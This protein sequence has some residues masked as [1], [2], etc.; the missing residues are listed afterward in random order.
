MNSPRISAMFRARRGVFAAR[1]PARA[2]IM[3]C[4]LILA[5]GAAW[6]D[7]PTADPAVQ[8]PAGQPGG[9]ITPPPATVPPT[10]LARWLNPATAPFLPVP[11]IG[12][13]PDSGTTLG[14]LP[15][16]LVTDENGDI[17]SII[18]PDILHN[19]FFGYGGHARIYDYPSADTQW[20]VVAGID[21]R[22]QRGFDAEYQTGRLRETRWSINGSFVYSHDGTPRFYGIG[23]QSPGIAETDYTQQQELL[24]I[25]VGYNL[26][27]AWQLLY[28]ARVQVVDVLPGTL[29]GIASLQS[30]FGHILGIGTN[31]QRLS[32]I[33][34]GY[35]TRDNIT[36]PSTG[37][38]WVAYVGGAARNGLINDSMY[39]ETGVDG[40]DFWSIRPGTVLATHMSLRYLPTSYDVPFWALSSLGG[41]Q[42]AV[43]GDQ[44]LRGYGPGRYYDRDAF[45]ATA[46]LRQRVANINAASSHVEIELTPF[47]DVGRVFGSTGT[48]PLSQLHT[49]AGIGVRG[50][51]RP[52]VVGYVDFG[53]GNEG[54]AVFTGI[55]Y[56]F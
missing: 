30:R 50:L 12:V 37:M 34:I 43:G 2:R 24:Q 26:N 38:E 29:E 21:E 55:N 47:V 1:N 23:N 20:S 31:Q 6:A 49:V 14:I 52:F 56:P 17:R 13:D 51:A 46:E 28:T 4:C 32:R 48:F 11:L 42:S 41:D 22:V 25:Q 35:D 3:G 7:D 27:H 33:S 15:V 53:Y 9:V 36:A 18:A 54:L 16:K 39:S 44:P 5:L 19:P 10:G 40:R 8:V 45:S